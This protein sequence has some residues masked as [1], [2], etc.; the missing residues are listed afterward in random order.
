[1][2][3]VNH[4]LVDDASNHLGIHTPTYLNPPM[5]NHLEKCGTTHQ[6]CGPTYPEFSGDN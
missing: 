4:C 6:A 1:M 5:A 3:N 2:H